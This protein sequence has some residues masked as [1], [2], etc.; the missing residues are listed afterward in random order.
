MG[1]FLRNI[2]EILKKHWGCLVQNL[3]FLKE[4][5]FEMTYFF[6]IFDSLKIPK[7]DC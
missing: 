3:F 2:E 7:K 4:S 1:K 6:Q 5:V